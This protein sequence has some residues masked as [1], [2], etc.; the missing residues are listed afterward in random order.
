MSPPKR[1]FIPTIQRVLIIGIVG[2]MSVYGIAWFFVL[3]F[4]CTPVHLF[5]TRS[6]GDTNGSC[7]SN[8]I[9]AGVAYSHSGL[10]ALS[11]FIM[12]LLPVWIVWDVNMPRRTKFTVAGLL[13]IG[14]S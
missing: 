11:D 7:L 2:I 5:W 14:A 9:E 4:Q 3:L 10:S 13:A 8:D 12:G 1:R 6:Y